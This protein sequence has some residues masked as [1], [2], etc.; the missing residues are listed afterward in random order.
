MTAKEYL[1]IIQLRDEQINQKIRELEYL[2]RHRTV[3][4][5][6][7]Y[8]KEKTSRS[9]S[10][11]ALFERG[12]DTVVDLIAEINREIDTLNIDK[13]NIINQ[14]QGLG[15]CKFVKILYKRYVEYKDFVVIAN[16]MNYSYAYIRE[17][18]AKALEN[19]EKSYKLLQTPT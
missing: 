12:S 3:I 18:H 1:E 14:I 11:E 16:E 17:L 15:D 10:R 19:F 9:I 8:S 7:D 4:S 2:Q 6:V 13:H 5:A